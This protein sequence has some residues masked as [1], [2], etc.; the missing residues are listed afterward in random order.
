M[1]IFPSEGYA[2]FNAY[3]GHLFHGLDMAFGL[4]TGFP[5]KSQEHLFGDDQRQ[6]NNKFGGL[7]VGYWNP[8]LPFSDGRRS[9]AFKLVL[10]EALLLRQFQANVHSFATKT[11]TFSK[12]RSYHGHWSCF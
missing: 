3:H 1:G 8:D 6:V 7:Y 4:I 2:R 5:T 9:D 11:P 10:E 12:E